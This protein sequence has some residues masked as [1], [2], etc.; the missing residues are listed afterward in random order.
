MWISKFLM[1]IVSVSLVLTGCVISQGRNDIKDEDL[2]QF[3]IGKTSYQEVIQKLGRPTADKFQKI[4]VNGKD[5]STRY[6]IYDMAN[7]VSTVSGA[8]FIPVVGALIGTT[9]TKSSFKRYTFIF[10]TKSGILEQMNTVDL[11]E[12]NSKSEGLANGTLGSVTTDGQTTTG[13]D[14]LNNSKYQMK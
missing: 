12:S 8:S 1:A 2:K 5:S 7:S 13:A 4:V 3:V 14:M 9:E 6:V 11:G 10:N